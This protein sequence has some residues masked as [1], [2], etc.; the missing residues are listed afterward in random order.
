MRDTPL[1]N[2]VRFHLIVHKGINLKEWD[3][4]LQ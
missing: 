4:S 1:L 3:M 2:L